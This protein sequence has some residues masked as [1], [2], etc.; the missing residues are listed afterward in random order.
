MFN[1]RVHKPGTRYGMWG[2][3]SFGKFTIPRAKRKRADKALKESEERYRA[4]FEGAAEGIL[5]ADVE[6][7][8]FKY[9]NPGICRMLG[10]TEQELKRMSVSDIHPK[11]DLEYVISDFEAHTRT[12]KVLTPEIPCLRKDGTTIYADIKSTKILLDGRDCH[13]GF[14]TDI[15]ERR[16]A[17]EAIERITNEQAV[18]LSTIPAMIFWTD[19]D[20]TFIRVNDAFAA[21]LHK[22]PD[23]IKGKSLFDLYPEDMAREYSDDNVRVMKSGASKR[24]IEEP[25]QTPTG[26]MWVSTD[27]I[28]YRDKKGDIIGIIGFSQDITERKRAEKALES[29][30]GLQ[31]VVATVSRSFIN[32]APNE[33]DNG[34]NLALETTGAFSEVDRSYVLLS[35]D[36]GTKMNNTHEWCA[37][38][39]EPQIENLQELSADMA[40][41]WMDKLN[42]F[43]NIHIPCVADLPPEASAEKQI[44]QAQDIQSLIVVP[45][46]CGNSLVGFIGFDSVRVEKTWPEESIVLLRLIAEIFANALER[47][48]AEEALEKSNEELKAQTQSLEQLNAALSVLLERREKDK[49]ELEEKVVSNV[50]ELVLP[51]LESLRKSQLDAKQATCVNIVESN[52]REIVSPFLRKLTSMYFGLTPKEIQ[53]AGLIKQGKTTKEIAEFLC[54]STSA[55]QFH[56]HNIRAKLGLK[57]QQANLGTYLMSLSQC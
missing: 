33:I 50:K 6:T 32:L 36:N 23:D 43:E 30:L 26:T 2:H 39:I 48:R 10:Y 42:R 38:G 15:T 8:E 40:P 3:K 1:F 47:R 21:A 28:P 45:M 16:Q 14:F 7:K 24:D 51:Y 11:D 25:V 20:G 13:V 4:V 29:Q 19:R 52:L 9:A 12:A 35:Y 17:E 41:W 27:K 49:E 44:L 18:L 34:I 22:S 31:Q 53:I 37:E 55:V 56:R 54:V 46:V 5:V 57:N